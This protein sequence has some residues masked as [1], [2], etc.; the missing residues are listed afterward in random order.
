MLEDAL[1]EA[2]EAGGEE[3]ERI[4]L[5]QLLDQRLIELAA[6]R[7]ERD[8]AAPRR[9]PVDGLERGADDVDAQHHPGAAAVGLV[10]DLTA[11]QRRVVPVV[12]EAEIQAG[13]QDRGHGALLGEPRE[14]V[15]K[16]GEDVDL[17]RVRD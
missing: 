1:V 5:G 14:G 3:G 9:V 6:L 11:R 10:V 7:R 15:R 4:G 8:H 2:L 13:A 12:E 17:H 16:Q